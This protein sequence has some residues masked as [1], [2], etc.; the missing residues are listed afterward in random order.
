MSLEAWGDEGGDD[1]GADRLLD[2]GWLNADDA[3]AMRADAAK[4]RS[5]VNRAHNAIG[6]GRYD[7]AAVRGWLRDAEELLEPR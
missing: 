5:L 4:A 6:T 2:A 7:R 3:E 1:C